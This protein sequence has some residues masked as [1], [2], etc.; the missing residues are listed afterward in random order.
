[1]SIPLENLLNEIQSFDVICTASS[2]TFSKLIKYSES[3]VNGSGGVH[4]HVALCIRGDVFPPNTMLV[5]GD[6]DL[7]QKSYK[8][9]IDY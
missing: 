7:S 4:S 1:M 2:T 9:Q 6:I 8:M 3:F 5:N